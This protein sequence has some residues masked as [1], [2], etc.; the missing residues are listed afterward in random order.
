MSTGRPVHG[1]CIGHSL[2][3]PRVA[4]LTE[5]SE[6]LIKTVLE[7]ADSISRQIHKTKR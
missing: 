1:R 7:V 3:P 4:W 5:R 2:E 6:A